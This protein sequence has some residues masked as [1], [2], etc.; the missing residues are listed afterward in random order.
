MTAVEVAVG[1]YQVAAAAARCQQHCVGGGLPQQQDG[2]AAAGRCWGQAATAGREVLVC[3]GSIIE[4]A[5]GGGNSERV[6]MGGG[7]SREMLGSAGMC[8][9]V[10]AAALMW[11]CMATAAD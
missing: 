8:R 6:P 11:Q 2:W 3:G 4:V 9:W 1:R 5:V 10:A 7:N